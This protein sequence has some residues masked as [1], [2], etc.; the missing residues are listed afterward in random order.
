MHADFFDYHLPPELIAQ[1]PSAERDKSRLLVVRRSTQTIEHRIFEDLPGLL[2]P[3][4]L[5]VLND[6]RVVP[7]RLVGRRAR[8]GGRWEG[9]FLREL[10]DRIWEILS[11][12]RGKLTAGEEIQ[13]EPGPLRLQ[14]L[15]K[16]AEGHW[17]VRPFLE[18]RTLVSG[19]HSEDKAEQ[20]A[21]ELL[22]RHGQVPLPPYIRKG[23]ASPDDRERYQTVYARE[24][25][26][27]AA[28]TAGFHFTSRVFE[29]LRERGIDW[30]YLTLHVGLGTF[31]PIQVE[32]IAKHVMHREWGELSAEA[33]DAIAACKFRGGKVI[34]VGTTSVRV[35]E[36][37]AA[38]SA[39]EGASGRQFAS[40]PLPLSPSPSPSIEAW[41]GE[42]D[43][44]IYPPFQF[45]AVDALV[46]NFHLPRTT[47][48]LLVSAFAGTDLIQRA[49]Q[50][51]I[52]ERY[53][54]FSYGDAMVIL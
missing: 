22:E 48:L 13:V 9:L 54:F 47:L 24:A 51:A 45:R 6:T 7:A 18:P 29:H 33:A 50:T 16:T 36:T 23:Q 49:Y 42:T 5:L 19:L 8:T 10:L 11:K 20:T 38:Y 25:G 17:L 4:D 32:D 2:N 1:E 52:E 34:A 31:Q 53:R 41:H 40:P 21:L 12:S 15:E 35:L 37:V 43:L 26:A 28:P 14:L 30:T 3:G 46:T 39:R 44:Y 27:V